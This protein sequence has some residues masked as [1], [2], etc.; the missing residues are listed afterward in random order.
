MCRTSVERRVVKVSSIAGEVP[1]IP[2]SDD[3]TDGSWIATDV[4]VG[5]MFF[6]SADGIMYTRSSNGIEVVGG[7]AG[8][9]KEYYAIIT[10]TGTSAPTVNTLIK[11][12]IGSVAFAYDNPGEFALNSAALF[13]SNK[14]VFAIV[15]SPTSGTSVLFWNSSSKIVL[16][17]SQ[18]GGG[19]FINGQLTKA[20]IHIIVLP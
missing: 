13:K 12:T 4:Y 17:T 3:H 1:T 6:N 8:A 15:P 9:I 18:D 7:G 5:E 19:G 11:N 2:A 20:T 16:K 14:T 10:Q